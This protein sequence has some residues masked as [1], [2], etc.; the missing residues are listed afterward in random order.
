MWAGW[1]QFARG[2][3]SPPFALLWTGQ[4]ISVLGDAVF[5]IALTWEVLRLTGSSTA[6]SLLV[7]AQWGPKLLLLAFGGGIADRLP[8]RLL[9][10]WADVMRGCIVFVLAWLAWTPALPFWLLLGLAPLFGIGRSFFDP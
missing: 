7:I 8:R 4:T 9:M 1:W 10:L 2:L 6:M 3:R 5:T